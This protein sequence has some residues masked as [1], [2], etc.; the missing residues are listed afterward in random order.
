MRARSLL[1]AMAVAGCGG[2]TTKSTARTALTRT[3]S[4]S[5]AASSKALDLDCENT[6]A[7]GRR[8]LGGKDWRRKAVPVGAISIIRG[9]SWVVVRPRRAHS[10]QSSQS[11]CG[12]TSARC[13]TST[14]AAPAGSSSREEEGW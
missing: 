4:S 6:F 14:L 7:P 11:F 12:R 13:S 10:S 3:D 1:L 2:S 8:F 5:A 9:P